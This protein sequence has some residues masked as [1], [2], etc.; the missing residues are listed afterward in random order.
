MAINILPENIANQIA[1]GEVVNR[2]A[3]AV[4]ELMENAVDAGSSSIT[5]I[6]KDAGRTL[7][8][9]IDNG[10]GMDEA[11][12]QKC[13]LPHA[14]SKIKAESDLRNLTTM[15]FRGEALASIAAIA[16]VELRTKQEDE[17]LANEIIIEGGDIK[18]VSK[19]TSPKGTDIK[20]KNIFFNVPARRNFLKSD[21]VE[22]SHITEAFIRIALINPQIAFTYIKD[23]QTIYKLDKSTLRKR[24]VD[25]FGSGFSKHLLEIKEKIDLVEI[26]GFIS[27]IDLT[28][29]S[30]NYE[31]FFVNNRYMKSPYFANAV[32]RAYSSLIPPK[33]YP[34]F[35]IHLKVNPKDI[36]VNIHP[37][38]TEVKFLDDKII[39][40]ILNAT[41]RKALGQSA[42]ASTLS[43]EKEPITFPSPDKN[44]IPTQPK[45]NYN[46]S[47]N[48]FA[49]QTA[50]PSFDFSAPV[51]KVKVQTEISFNGENVSS[52]QNDNSQV[53][54]TIRPFQF[55]N[56]YIVYQNNNSIL[57]I[58]QFNASKKVIH[59]FLKGKTSMILPSEKLLLP[60][61]HKFSQLEIISLQAREDLLRN[62]G[63]EFTVN[64]DDSVDFTSMPKEM[65]TLAAMNLINEVISEDINEDDKPLLIADRLAIR[66]GKILSK[67]EMTNL[68]NQLLQ[69]NNPEF[70]PMNERVFLRLDN[71][72]LNKF[73]F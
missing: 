18:S 44:Y 51:N 45:L 11:D 71:T 62:I 63:F 35:F 70:L 28:K 10:C 21:S 17:E 40:S 48:P 43:F 32:E 50:N 9:V 47:F 23:G 61:T 3:S 67:N 72:F 6:I 4:K 36:D 59:D 1:A 49:K 39:Y 57:L 20:V 33:T 52:S 55:L 68:I 26:V 38:K 12:A 30:K 53:T 2:P 34:C 27:T 46:S 7:V 58:N 25:I 42:V 65:T 13:F 31:Y 22:G 29:K 69:C 37:T 64:E 14:T 19:T 60:Y 54:E 24:I 8:E 41:V 16:Q 66:N 5:L 15:G 56:K 73:F